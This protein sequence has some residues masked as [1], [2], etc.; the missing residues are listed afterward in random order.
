MKMVKHQKLAEA[1]ASLKL[2]DKE[3]TDKLSDI[4][5]HNF[6][7]SIA[8]L[9]QKK[10]TTA[11]VSGW[12]KGTAHPTNL[13]I[14]Q[15]ISILLTGHKDKYGSFIVSSQK[16]AKKILHDALSTNNQKIM[17]K[18]EDFKMACASGA[19]DKTRSYPDST[20]IN[21]ETLMEC[22]AYLIIQGYLFTDF[23]HAKG[24]LTLD[25][26]SRIVDIESLVS[27]TDIDNLLSNLQFFCN[28]AKKI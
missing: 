7:M 6:E 13:T 16:E 20:K 10:L 26:Y 8:D 23:S 27:Q 11:N 5:N 4:I 2:T 14:R 12:R 21:S 9:V 18:F 22:I 28:T 1:L 25:N 3:L 15:G 17:D 24:H 19:Y